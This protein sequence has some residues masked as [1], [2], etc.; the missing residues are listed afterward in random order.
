MLPHADQ[1]GLTLS[2]GKLGDQ[3]S[4]LLEQRVTPQALAPHLQHG[5]GG[6]GDS[7]PRSIDRG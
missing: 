7:P 4:Q 2:D 5:R 1:R 6:A 3:P